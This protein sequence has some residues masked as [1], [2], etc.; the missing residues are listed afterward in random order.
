ME[1]K[2]KKLWIL[3]EERPKTSVIKSIVEKFCA[4]N[5]SA[6]L[7]GTIQF[8]PIL[9]NNGDFDF[10]Y[11]VLGF[12]ST[13]FEK[14]FIKTVTGK[15]SFVDFLVF[16]QEKEPTI[17]DDPLYIIEETKTDDTESRNTG[18][19][20]R[21]SKFVYA[22]AIYPNT[23]KIM[24]YN[25]QIE[26]GDSPTLTNQFGTKCLFTIG[27][28]ILGK[29][30]NK[31]KDG[32]KNL[33][34]LIDF[35]Q[36][37]PKP[38]YGVPIEITEYKDRIEVSGRLFKSTGL[39]YDP[40]IGALTLIA[41]RLRKLGWSKRIVITKHGL[42]QK[43]VTPRNKFIRIANLINIELEGLTI[44]ES[45]PVDYWYYDESGEKLG[46]IFI[47]LAVENFTNGKS[48]FE[49]HAGSEKG[50]FIKSS[51]EKVALE[52]YKDRAG[53]K[54]GDKTQII[55]IPDLILIDFDNSEILNIEGEKY[56]NL[57]KGIEQ[58]KGFGDIE[59]L[60]IKPS[61]PKHK[62]LRT[63]VLFGG[64]TTEIKEIS[65][66]FLL[67]SRGCMVLGKQAPKLFTEAVNNLRDYWNKS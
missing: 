7:A 23:T 53:Y 48:I 51:G 46:T 55:Q 50:Y 57:Y 27:V 18:V 8:L 45:K 67:N 34:E 36:S 54:K 9:D 20:Q 2:N 25:I 44:P 64:R 60:Y 22:D 58:I 4:D 41:K 66:G 33:K 49:N 14:I 52:K 47:H 31:I 28:E 13:S 19:Y 39:N 59:D 35:N 24:L 63:I 10:T 16:Y 42:Q 6:A 38:P 37:I 21:A 12:K 32:F 62:I 43:H 56:E 17:D 15:T 26:E 5:K 11:E 40:N 1:N 61:Y 65:V 30:K 3:T 29:E